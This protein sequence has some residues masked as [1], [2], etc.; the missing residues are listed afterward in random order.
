MKL[1]LVPHKKFL[2][3]RNVVH[4]NKECNVS[5]NNFIIKW[6]PDTCFEHVGYTT[7][8]IDFTNVLL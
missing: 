7:G 6:T 3:Q 2:F 1:Y 4:K 8:N 5:N